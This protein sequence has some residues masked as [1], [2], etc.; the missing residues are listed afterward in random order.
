DDVST[1]LVSSG[2][3]ISPKPMI[4]RSYY[5]P[6][7]R[8]REQVISVKPSHKKLVIPAHEVDEPKIP[9]KVE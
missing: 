8:A 4:R 2:Q 5:D 9:A 7:V 1:T 3:E 6:A